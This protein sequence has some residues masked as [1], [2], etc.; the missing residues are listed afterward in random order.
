MNEIMTVIVSSF[1]CI[2]RPLGMFIILPIFSTGVLLSNFIRNSIM[3]AF[4]LPIIVENYTFSEKLPSGI[5]QLTGI[6]LK[7][8]SI[9]FFIGL[10]FTILFWAIDAA[11]QIIDT[12][13]GSTISSIFN[14]SI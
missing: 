9:G 12:L 8:I 13:R 14:P 10:S 3:I 1:F 2:L 6:V 11:G 7:E 5:F 4:T